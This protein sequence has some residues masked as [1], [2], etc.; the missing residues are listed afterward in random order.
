MTRAFL[1]GNEAFAEGVRLARV[2]VVSAYPITP[3]TTVVESLASM[4][5]NGKLKA[6]YLHV[7]S[8]H[9]ALSAAIGA[10]MT[11]ARTFTA[12]SSQGLLYMAECLVYAAGGRH[13]I[14]MMNA[15]RSTALPWNIYGD[16]RDSLLLADSGW[17]QIY[18]RDAQ[19]ALDLCLIAYRVAEDPEVSTPCM[20][21]LDGFTITHT[22]EAVDVPS[23]EQADAFLPP[24]KTENKFDFAAPKNL[25]FSA[26]PE[27]N[28]AFK[29]RE[30][31]AMLKVFGKLEE[32]EDDFARIFGRRY[33]GAI[34]SWGTEDAEVVVITLG[35]LYGLALE[36]AK[37]LRKQGIRAG[38]LRLRLIRPFPAAQLAAALAKVP[39]AAVI[40]KDVSFGYEGAVCTW[41]RAALQKAGAG[42]KV[43]GFV[44]GLG[45]RDVP[46]EYVE[47]AAK[48]ALAGFSGTR[49]QG[50]EEEEF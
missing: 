47:D 49:F 2:Q 22:Y 40:E 9:S 4:V 41:V 21:C 6:R 34:E 38:A 7:E 31:E 1:S 48:S 25:A 45:G 43:C 16:Q 12:T 11:G 32:A 14:V 37:S 10:S 28:Y 5:A 15:C 18:A 3:Q 33:T 23:Q 39:H 50:F 19:E 30:H 17:I 24:F 8:E 35:A 36:A 42:A 44:A 29:K 13:P 27:T 26:G 20:V 46:R